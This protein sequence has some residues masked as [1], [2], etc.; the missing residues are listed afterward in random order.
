MK[1]C[2]C[3]QFLEAVLTVGKPLSG[4]AAEHVRQCPECAALRAQAERLTGR[5]EMEPPAVLDRAV[6]AHAHDAVR[7]QSVHQLF[8]RRIMPFAAAAAAAVVCVAVLLPDTPAAD[9]AVKVAQ[10]VPVKLTELPV[11]TSLEKLETEAFDLS[12]ELT[13]CQNVVTDWQIL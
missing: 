4:A 12:Q 9:P 5:C 11:L 3:E 6:L 7:R 13:S 8:F 10:T 1:P 2:G